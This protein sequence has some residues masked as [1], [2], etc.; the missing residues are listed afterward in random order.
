MSNQFLFGLNN[1][2]RLEW[3][4]L[5]KNRDREERLELWKKTNDM[6]IKHVMIQREKWTSWE[7][8]VRE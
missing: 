2:I 3:N 7:S 4:G 1:N 5:K 6:L 8:G